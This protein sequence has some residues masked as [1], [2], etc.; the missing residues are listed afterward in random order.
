MRQL[1]LLAVCPIV[2]SSCSAKPAPGA[3]SARFTNA[4][5]VLDS[6]KSR[7]VASSTGIGR[8]RFGMT[9]KALGTALGDS[10][11]AATVSTTSCTYVR[12]KAVPRGIGLMISNGTVVRADVD[13][14]G[15]LTEAGIG[16]GDSEV[17]VL[18]INSGRVRVEPGKYAGLQSHTL[19]V[20]DPGDPE[21]AMIFETDGGKVRTFRAGVR[22]AVELVERCG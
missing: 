16:V 14:A 1:V 2:L 4:T 21:H 11:L 7:W 5:G 15:I 18:V 3:D 13:S 19:T 9:L 17:S 10:A 22:S 12:P 6:E 20:A 8:V